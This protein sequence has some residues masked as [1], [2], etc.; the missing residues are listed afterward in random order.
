MTKRKRTPSPTPPR[1]RVMF[2]VPQSLWRFQAIAR[3]LARQ[4]ELLLQ[5]LSDSQD[6]QPGEAQSLAPGA[7]HFDAQTFQNS[8]LRFSPYSH[9]AFLP[10]QPWPQ[11]AK[12]ASASPEFTSNAT[13]AANLPMS[14]AEGTQHEGHTRQISTG[15]DDQLFE[16][17]NDALHAE[18]VEDPHGTGAQS[19]YLTGGN[20][21]TFDP[22]LPNEWNGMRPEQYQPFIQNNYPQM[23]P[24]VPQSGFSPTSTLAHH[25]ARPSSTTNY[26]PSS[27]TNPPSFYHPPP[28][29][30]GAHT[31]SNL[32]GY[33]KS[34]LKLW[35]QEDQSAN[36]PPRSAP[37]PTHPFGSMNSAY[38]PVPYPTD[39]T[40]YAL[41]PP[42][43]LAS[44][45]VTAYTNYGRSR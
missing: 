27:S 42:P 1:K 29:Q 43:P 5:Q 2:E 30:N 18:E 44:S 39:T 24:P 36:A 15:P 14:R 21:I 13:T 38:P 33:Y 31:K 37:Q 41:H 3:E 35:S 17:L 4:S 20:R 25:P 32:P 40:T 12:S 45:P 26:L 10:S 9:Q 22:H 8:A 23:A 6:Q 16:E 19:Q 34:S 7:P 28:S 11:A